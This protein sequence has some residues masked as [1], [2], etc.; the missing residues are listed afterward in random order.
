[1]EVEL[2][3]TYVC[4]R[5]YNRGRDVVQY[6]I[7]GGIERVSKKRFLVSLNGDP[8]DAN[9]LMNYVRRYVRTGSICYTDA[10]RS[11]NRLTS[12]GYTHRVINHSANFVRQLP[13]VSI[14]TQ[15]VERLW[16]NMKE[17][18]KRRGRSPKHLKYMICRY[19]FIKSFED[20][21]TRFHNFLVGW[22]S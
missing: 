9:T 8:R 6:W 22:L 10:H 15:T 4:K 1:M 11:Y 13:G 19:I 5:K 14:H 18:V 20:H 2:D 17:F 21:Q 16:G 3:E 7:F 12:L